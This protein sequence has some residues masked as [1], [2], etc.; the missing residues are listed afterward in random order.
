MSRLLH[1]LF[2]LALYFLLLLSPLFL[3]LLPPTP[4]PRAFL[5]ELS[6]A[7]GFISLMQI[8]LQFVLIA[9]FR[10]VTEPYGI[11]IILQYHRQI[12]LGSLLLITAHA[13]IAISTNPVILGRLFDAGSGGSALLSGL[14][15]ALAFVL[16]VVL[17]LARQRLRL[18][19]E[20]WR[21]SHALLGIAMIGLAVT[22]VAQVGIYVNAGWKRG[23]WT[24]FA[25]LVIAVLVYLRLLHPALQKATSYRVVSVD[26]DRGRTWILGVEPEGHPGM[27]FLPGQ[28][29]YLKLGS[30]PHTI[31]EHPFSF[32][33]SGET[34]DRLEFGIKELGDFTSTIGATPL[35]TN[36]YLDG[37]HG[38]MSIDIY[39]AAGYV[40]VAGGIGV[41]PIVSMLRAMADRGDARPN[42]L[43]YADGAWD[44]MPFRDDLEA[45]AQ[46]MTLD[47]VHVLERPPEGW[48]GETGRVTAE[49][50]ARCLP[51]ERIQRDFFVCGPNAM[52]DSV[53]TALAGLGIASRFIH[54]ERFTLV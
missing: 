25:V 46:R 34:P 3:M 10:P 42:L 41:T 31:Q 14:G 47:V 4:V 17:S 44:D 9:R 50:L 23:L 13:A 11:D 29:V 28:F 21:I 19:Y 37:P 5:T 33:S 30:S 35:G 18:G 43:I 51:D 1:G 48:R 15:A 16:L 32:S 7:I 38:S 27:R 39:P 12:G 36:A 26:R 20:A 49:L 2:W 6:A 45:L 8:G 40:F 53:E 54:A 22:H 52:I 24:G